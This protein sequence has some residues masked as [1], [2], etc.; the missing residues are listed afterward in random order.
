MHIFYMFYILCSI[1]RKNNWRAVQNS[2]CTQLTGGRGRARHADGEVGLRPLAARRW[3]PRT[4][5]ISLEQRSAGGGAGPVGS[6]L[7]SMTRR[8]IR[9]LPRFLLASSSSEFRHLLWGF[10]HLLWG[11][12]EACSAWEDAPQRRL[13][14][15]RR[16]GGAVAPPRRGAVLAGK[17]G[18][19]HT[20]QH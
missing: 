14:A 11:F 10:R 20:R 1:S 15:R 18:Q 12:L 19:T 13:E 3:P 7:P 4:Q 8:A 17:K 9:P 2:F 16:N 6:A 5:N